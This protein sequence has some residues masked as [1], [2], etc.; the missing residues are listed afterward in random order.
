MCSVII[1]WLWLIAPQ[2]KTIDSVLTGT[3]KNSCFFIFLLSHQQVCFS[4]SL[5]SPLM[6]LA[7]PHI[8]YIETVFSFQVRPPFLLFSAH[9]QMCLH[10]CSHVC[11][12]SCV[13]GLTIR[14]PEF[15]GQ[16][17]SCQ[18]GLI[19]GEKEGMSERK[20]FL[21]KKLE[22]AC[23]MIILAVRT[24]LSLF[25]LSQQQPAELYL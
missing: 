17:N 5:F 19:P 6:F 23:E 25:L 22:T 21:D 13:H 24:R 2:M 14:N 9:F 7:L 16:I 8:L 1:Y 4:P 11:C 20:R 15:R 10:V 3:L 12:R 18:K